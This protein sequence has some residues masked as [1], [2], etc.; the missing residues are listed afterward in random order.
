MLL[1]V[2]GEHF[3]DEPCPQAPLATVATESILLWC[4]AEEGR[5]LSPAVVKMGRWEGSVSVSVRF[6]DFTQVVFP[7]LGICLGL[8]ISSVLNTEN[9][10]AK[11]TFP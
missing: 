8:A 7:S 9:S 5:S 6:Y 1:L 4:G 2:R 10:L 11:C 3:T